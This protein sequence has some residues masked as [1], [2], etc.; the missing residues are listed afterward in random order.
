M[1]AGNRDIARVLIKG[2]YWSHVNSI[3]SEANYTC[4]LHFLGPQSLRG[5]NLYRNT[6]WEKSKN[7]QPQ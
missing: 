7:I 5:T 1:R 4:K 3:K 2:G 6:Q